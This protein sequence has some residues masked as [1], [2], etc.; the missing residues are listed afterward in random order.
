M[1]SRILSS[2]VIGPRVLAPRLAF[3]GG[4]L[5]VVPELVTSPTRLLQMHRV[6]KAGDTL[7]IDEV[8]KGYDGS[9]QNLAGATV[10][11][12][13]VAPDGSPTAYDRE[14]VTVRNAAQGS[15]RFRGTVPTALGVYQYEFEAT[16][17]DGDPGTDR[18][19]PDDSNGELTVIPQLA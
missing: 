16:W 2:R 14:P 3:A 10:V 7:I 9:V 19:F 5:N 18:T 6:A 8:L 12:T 13:L 15:V 17:D 1:S 11:F 4:A